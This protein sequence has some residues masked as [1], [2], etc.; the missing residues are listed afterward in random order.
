VRWGF[1]AGSGKGRADALENLAAV[2]DGLAIAYGFTAHAIPAVA[3][4]VASVALRVVARLIGDG[5][6]S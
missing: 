5:D 3:A 4:G 1:G 2:G 6:R